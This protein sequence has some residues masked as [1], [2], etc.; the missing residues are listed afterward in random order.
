MSGLE[1]IQNR[2]VLI[3]SSHAL[4]GQ[5][6]L[7]LLLERQDAGIQIV[8][9]V[10]NLDQAMHALEELTPDLVI[11]DY[12]DQALNR[13]EFLA[14]FVGGEKKLRVV[15]LSLQSANEAIVY[16]R[17][18]LAAAQIDDW[19]KEWSFS[20][21]ETQVKNP[22]P[23]GK[24]LQGDNRR[25]NMK[26]LVIAGMLVLLVTAILILGLENVRLLPV[27]ASVQAQTIDRLFSLEFKVIAFL[28]S[29]IV[30][31]MLYSIIFFRRKPGDTSDAAHIE[32]NTR[33]EVAWTIAPLITV[34]VF[35]YLGGQ[36]LAETLRADPKALEIN[37]IGRQWAWRFEYPQSGVTSDTLIL[38]LN[39]QAI[40]YL[41]S[42]DVIHSFWVPEFRVKQ[43]ALPGGEDFIRALRITPSM[44]G[45]YKVR[46]AE[47][48]GT[49][50]ATMQSPVKVVSQEAFT[51]WLASQSVEITD[52]VAL[53]EKWVKESGCTACHSLDGSKL[54][55]PTWAGLYGSQE[56]LSDGS[57]VTVDDAYI[58][59]SILNPNKLIVTGY[60]P[61][62]MP[63]NYSD[64]LTLDQIQQIIAFIKTLQ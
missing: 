43:D 24:I 47:L 29:L 56:E 25:N 1:S 6:L 52:P 61:N 62:L 15:L 31:F 32:G 50:H 16:D 18:T 21:Q 58:Q 34:L 39:K 51:E 54:V 22:L 44:L 49:Q 2:R 63:A 38:P 26:H 14:R 19:L 8:G 28:F 4:F 48:C 55:G 46:C 10:S 33:L 64:Q 59:E 27:Q 60:P 11:V 17:R 41:R 42:E 12:D 3:A 20:T 57:L 5:G 13:D 40:L 45:D 36:S 53:G 30:V 37:V 23:Q 7:S 9:M 35:A